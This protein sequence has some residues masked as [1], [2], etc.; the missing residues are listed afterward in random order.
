MT[1]PIIW[2]PERLPLSALLP[3]K[4]KRNPR[5]S[6]KRTAENLA[7]TKERFAQPYP[8][9]IDLNGDM[10][11]GH[12]RI[13]A[14]A[15]KWGKDLVV[16]V[17]RANRE[18][19][20]EERQEFV[21]LFHQGAFGQWDY[22]ALANFDPAQLATFG[23]DQDALDQ[24][25]REMAFLIEMLGEGEGEA[26][27]GEEGDAEPQIDKAAEL[28]AEWGTELGQLWHIGEHRLLIGDCTVGENVARLMGGEKA[29]ICWT[30]PPWNVAYG[31][32]IQKGNPQGWKHR[33]IANDNLGK[34]FVNFAQLFCSTI[35]GVLVDGGM[36]YMAMSAQEWGTIMTTLDNAGFHWSSTIIWN[37]DQLVMSRK[38]YHTKYEPIWYGWAGNSP[39]VHPLE[40]RKQSDVWDIP[41]PKRSDEHPTM[42]P[43]ELVSRS[44]SNSS[45]NHS[46]AFDPFLGSGTTMVAAHNLGR[47]CYGME[48]SPAYGAVILQ[49]MITAFPDINIYKAE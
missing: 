19:S 41:R 10:V 15:H 43:V 26:Q 42:K 37:K 14:W 30:D 32:N 2:T 18:F 13:D 27:A 1:E 29:E 39:R 40:D 20:E 45:G 44:L 11:D 38:D 25:R 16:D 47:K 12:Q 6:S 24:T 34:D 22:D 8:I 31:E 17:S 28:Q 23:F 49:R 35:Y 48:L 46:I 3:K 7:A 9:L 21:L 33:S 36:L 4:W 5:Q